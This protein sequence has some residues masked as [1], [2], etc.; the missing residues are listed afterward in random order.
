[1][2]KKKLLIEERNSILS[3]MN[4]IVSDLTKTKDDREIRMLNKEFENKKKRIELIDQ[5]IKKV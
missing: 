2:N 1:M 3:D 4:L 5:T